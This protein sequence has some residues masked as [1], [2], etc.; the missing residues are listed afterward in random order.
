MTQYAMV[1]VISTFRNRYA[2][3][4]DQLQALNPEVPIEGLELEWAEDCVTCED[5]E[6]FSQKHLGETIIDSVLLDETQL[7]ELFDKD[8]DYLN[9]WTKEQKLSWVT[10]W[11]RNMLTY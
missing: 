6:E 10:K 7:L 9:E 2:I 5:V 3:P 4:V 11:R 1:T 8:N